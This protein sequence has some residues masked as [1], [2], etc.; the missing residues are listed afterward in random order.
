[1]GRWLEKARKR[2]DDVPTKLTEPGFVGFVSTPS[3]RFQEKAP[4]ELVAANE[5]TPPWLHLLALADGRV[6]QRC[7]EQSTVRVEEDARLQHGDD[8]PSVV[9]VPGFERPLTEEEIVKVLA[10]TLAAPASP[11]PPSSVW[12]ARVAR[13]LDTR[14]AELLEGG[15]LQQHD[16]AELAGTNV[17]LVADHIRHSPAWLNRPQ[18]NEQADAGAAPLY[19]PVPIG[20]NGR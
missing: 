3:S 12:L 15:H 2:S 4:V 13:L 16:L 5:I 6:V 14:P 19:Q 10:G 7:G 18:Y 9:A 8:L 1:M 11:P 17:A 20:A